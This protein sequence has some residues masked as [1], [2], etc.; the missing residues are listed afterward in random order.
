MALCQR[1]GRNAHQWSN[2]SEYVLKL[3]QPQY[4]NDPIVKYGYMRGSETADYVAKINQRW[5]DYRQVKSPR[6][7][8]TQAPRK[9]TRK[10]NKY[11]I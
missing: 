7:G 2:I 11:N 9:A 3:A 6:Q 8:F 1:D 4:Y 10:T 5:A